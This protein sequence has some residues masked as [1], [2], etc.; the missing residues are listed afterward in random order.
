MLYIKNKEMSLLSVLV[1]MVLFIQGQVFLSKPKLILDYKQ[2]L[3]VSSFQDE[4]S[5]E[6]EN[7]RIEDNTNTGYFYSEIV[8]ENKDPGL[9]GM[10]LELLGTAVGNIKDP[11]AFI[12]DT[13]VGKQ[14]I[15]RL[16]SQIKGAQVIKIALGEVV[17]DVNAARKF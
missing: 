9:V 1:M 7:S 12:K 16:G 10:E 13:R 6:K 2:G 8:R 17:L 3:F 11:I 5:I 14:G 4:L 15:Y